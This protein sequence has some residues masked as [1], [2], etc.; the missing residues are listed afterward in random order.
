MQ[1]E[2]IIIIEVRKRRTN[3]ICYHLYVESKIW[4]RGKEEEGGSR[5]K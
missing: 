3:T 2:M 5:G 4:Q 1:V